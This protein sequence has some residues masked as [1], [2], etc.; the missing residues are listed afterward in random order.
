MSRHSLLLLVLE[1]PVWVR[2]IKARRRPAIGS[3]GSRDEDDD[4]GV[5]DKPGEAGRS[6]MGRRHPEPS[7]S[8]RIPTNLKENGGWKVSSGDAMGAR[9]PLLQGEAEREMR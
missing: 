2:H 6:G 7:G 9:P 8:G 5:A 3:A 1:A 4:I